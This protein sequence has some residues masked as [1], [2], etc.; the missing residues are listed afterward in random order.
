[1][2]KPKPKKKLTLSQNPTASTANYTP[3]PAG[4]KKP[5]I[6]NTQQEGLDILQKLS[7]IGGRGV[8]RKIPFGIGASV[9]LT[10]SAINGEK[11]NF[12]DM[13]GLIPTGVGQA[14][15]LTMMYAEKEK[16][17]LQQFAANKMRGK[18]LTKL[19]P[20]DKE[21]NLAVR[22]TIPETKPLA[23]KKKTKSTTPV[24]SK[25]ST[26][27]LR[28]V[29]GTLMPDQA[30]QFLS[31]VATKDNKLGVDD[32]SPDIKE[33]LIKSVKNAQKRTGKDSGGTQYVDFGAEAEK[34]FQ[35]M[36]AGAGKMLSTDP[37]IQ[38]ASMV[39]R[40]SYKKNKKGETEIYDSYDFSKTDP[41]KADSLYKKIR[42]YAGEALPD[43][44][45]QPN[46]IGK[47]PATA[48]LAF[49][50]NQNGIMK[51]KMNPRK[52]YAA[53]TGAA[54]AGPTNYIVSP[55]Q[56]MND[57]NILLA[58][59]EAEAAANPWLP[60]VAT[61]GSA[62]QQ[63]ISIAGAAA[64]K[65][66]ASGVNDPNSPNYVPKVG[67]GSNHLKG[68]VEV[69]GGER[70]E[71]PQ[72]KTGEFKG[73]SHEKGGI[74]L[75]VSAF[76]MDLLQ[77]YAFGTGA[78]G[79]EGDPS[80]EV[81]E[82]PEG[83]IIY[84]DRLKV[85]K[86][87]LAERAANRERQIANIEKAASEPLVDQAIK[88]TLQRKM[89]AIQKEK[90]ADLDFQEKV[91]NMQQMADNVVAA[92]GTSIKGLQD[93]V[94][95]PMRYGYGTNAKGVQ[96]YADGTS[97][98]GIQYDENG[99]PIVGFAEGFGVN[100]DGYTG[101]QY[102]QSPNDRLFNAN[103]A[104]EDYLNSDTHKKAG[105]ALDNVINKTEADTKSMVE[106]GK[107]PPANTVVTPGVVTPA[108]TN[109]IVS[110]GKTGAPGFVDGF[111]MNVDQTEQDLQ[112]PQADSNFKFNPVDIPALDLKVPNVAE[113][114]VNSLKPKDPFALTAGEDWAKA[115]PLPEGMSAPISDS[116]NLKSE[117]FPEGFGTGTGTSTGTG[118]KESGFL[119]ALSGNM[120]AVGDMTKLIGNYLGM[121]SGIKT[122]G[123]QR[124]SDI[125]HTNVYANAGKESQKLLDNAKRGIEIN[126][127]QAIVKANSNTRG[128]KRGGRN[129][130]RGVNQMRA[131]DWLYD[132]A[133][134]QQ[135]A[136]ISA[137]AAQQISGI[138]VQ[139]SSV[140]MN[141]D[142]L[143][144]QGEYQAAMANE[145]AKDAYYTALGQG[146]KDFATGLQQTGKDLNAMKENK[147]IEN[148]MKKY[149]N[150]VQMD[151]QG[152]MTGKMS[153]KAEST[154][155]E[156]FTGPGGK[157]YKRG[158]DGNL[159]EVTV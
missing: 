106:T 147:I 60:I 24:T 91:N 51:T 46:L 36:K 32:L 98:N 159:I 144:G 155:E 16:E 11:S 65:K 107:L 141:A 48:Q 156:I 61:V 88:N 130:A 29:L 114:A 19:K 150:N 54:G 7:R 146:R 152:N 140:A 8:L 134:N 77:Q 127:N 14:A 47:I 70:Y 81:P 22:S 28:N 85:G 68:N 12:S 23:I 137:N 135:I 50:T 113:N 1:M 120:P 2:P 131:M 119:K 153:K 30:A 6:S 59:A 74:P 34:A 121:T 92:F 18:D 10:Q 93:S 25:T 5:V 158:K 129:S 115:N 133:L 142:Q 149:G 49:G 90:T 138:D 97:I 154:D 126:K 78:E 4:T 139:K 58:K 86:E 17:N 9:G 101:D 40:V 125:T 132:T 41:D 53:G 128:G 104:L 37:S 148:I 72:G 76:P 87:T 20:K 55:A 145:A 110:T 136:D 105:S 84:S 52:K 45:N 26:K 64:G 38:A 157:K 42:A 56:A 143:K 96:Q 73:P 117:F 95:N 103:K 83:T 13:L 44:G 99:N 33:A 66:A 123:E 3:K 89:Q 79:I 67:N 57:Y 21:L 31:A 122:A 80:Q 35:G 27:V 124:S 94:E 15:A 69:E 75:E 151:L 109:P 82:V 62:M 118:K 102:N 108:T 112:T 63:G 39:G 111:G 43:E 100:S 71:T 116:L